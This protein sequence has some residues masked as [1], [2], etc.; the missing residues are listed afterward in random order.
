MEVLA[1]LKG[2]E[3]GLI[4]IT[5]DEGEYSGRGRTLP[6]GSRTWR[7]RTLIHWPDLSITIDKWH[8]IA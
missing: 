2:V 3:V 4:F 5:F 7:G 8:S 1:E 6:A